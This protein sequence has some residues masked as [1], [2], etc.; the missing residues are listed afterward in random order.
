[1]TLIE[2]ITLTEYE[3]ILLTMEY[4][5]E[6]NEFNT[7]KWKKNGALDGTKDKVTGEFS[8][9]AILALIA[10]LK[11]FYHNVQVE[12]KGKGRHYIL[13]G[14]KE[15]QTERVFNYNSFASTP[16]GNIMIE[17]VFNRLLKI[18]TNTLSITRW[19]SLIGLPK[20][21]D[22][23]LKAAFEEMKELYSFNLGENTE[24]VI[25]KT[26]REIN[27][28]I[29]SR[30]VDIIRNAFNHLKKQNRIEITPL[31]YFRKIDGNVQVVDV[32]EYRELKA[33]IKILVEE[34]EVAY[35]DY[36]NARRFNNFH[37]EELRECNKIVKQHLK[38]QEIDYEFE[39]LFVDVVN[40]K[41]VR[42]LDEQEVNRAWCNNFISL[43][44]DKQKKEKYKNSQYLSKEFY[45]LNVCILLRAYLS[46]SQLSIIEEET[47]NLEKRF[48]TMYDRYVEAKLLEEE[49]EKPKGFGQTIEHTA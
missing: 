7:A 8:D 37:S 45:L 5:F 3:A 39:R 13:W 20:L 43:A 41:V 40:K 9:R 49:E 32:I 12:G 11:T 29:N 27:S 22:N 30:N 14:K 18:K 19:T 28:V 35:Q 36:M 24:K 46:K 17:Y 21:D 2:K 4:G 16:E 15:I 31:Y 42:E 25:N 10:K 23:S 34:Q 47:T 38:D 6:G 48:A 1:M 44:Q 26:I 33:D